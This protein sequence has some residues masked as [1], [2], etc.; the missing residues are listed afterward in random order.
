M[1]DTDHTAAPTAL[2]SCADRLVLMC[3]QIEQAHL[4]WTG[5]RFDWVAF[6]ARGPRAVG[7]GARPTASLP[8]NARVLTEEGL[9]LEAARPPA[10]WKPP[11]PKI[12]DLFAGTTS[13]KSRLQVLAALAA[14]AQL[15]V[16]CPCPVGFPDTSGGRSTLVNHPLG[17]P[18]P[19][20]I[21]TSIYS[22][23]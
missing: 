6:F 9:R 21:C 7:M 17:Q 18:F 15:V 2:Q 19:S 23:R 8:A 14:L 13:K 20:G 11:K 22:V 5:E 10:D 1:D 12:D 16:H 3:S 4:A